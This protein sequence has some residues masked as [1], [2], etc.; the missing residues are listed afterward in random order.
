MTERDF[1]CNYLGIDSW[2][3]DLV[4]SGQEGFRKQELLPWYHPTP[5]DGKEAGLQRTFGN[6]TFLT[7]HESSHFVPYSQPEA[8]LKMFNSWVHDKQP[9]Q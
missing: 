9:P 1:I 8:S 5:N 2:S 6:L 7:V 3:Q 4:W